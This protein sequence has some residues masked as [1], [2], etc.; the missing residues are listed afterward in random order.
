MKI[1]I[2]DQIAQ[3]GIDMLSQYAQVDVKTK[4]KPEQ[5]VPI[6]GDYEA[7]IVRSQTKVTAD[8]IAAG[9]KLQVI[10]RAGVGKQGP[11]RHRAGSHGHRISRESA[12]LIDR[13]ERRQL[14]HEF[15]AATVR[16]HRHTAA[17]DLSVGRDIRFD[18]VEAGGAIGT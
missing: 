10:G 2:A 17:N 15:A 4:Q 9:K 7:I 11:E 16:T 5:I 3:A 8:I 1:L 12:G 13:T 6:I 14:L 18:A